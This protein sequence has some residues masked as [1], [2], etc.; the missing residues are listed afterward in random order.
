LNQRANDH[1]KIGMPSQFSPILPL[2]RSCL[3]A[4][5]LAAVANA[6]PTPAPIGLWNGRDLTGWDVVLKEPAPAG[7]PIAGP[8]DAG[9]MQVR[10]KP[11]GYVATK[12]SFGDFELTVE[13][14]W[15]E[16]PGNSGVLL[17]LG[18]AEKDAVWPCCLQV[19]MKAGA[20]GDLLPM[21]GFTFAELPAGAKAVP[22]AVAATEVPAGGWNVCRI[23]CRGD[24]VEC[25]LNGVLA[26]RATK[27]SAKSGR[28]GIQLEGAPFELRGLIL[29]KL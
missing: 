16:Q 20:A 7:A 28:I 29:R 19:Q 12:E 6:A 23:V 18:S 14:R 25:W 21:E 8:G 5:C 24:T 26:N 27:C 2:L 17:H 9:I 3:L 11:I 4:S 13:W 22:R 1:I 15:P 10:G